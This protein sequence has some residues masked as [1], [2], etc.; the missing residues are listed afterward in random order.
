MTN[1]SLLCQLAIL[2]RNCQ[3][4]RDIRVSA[5]EL[6]R[7][8]RSGRKE[9][10]KIRESLVLFFY[11]SAVR[12]SYAKSSRLYAKDLQCPQ[13]W[14]ESLDALLPEPFRYLGSL[15]LFRALP[16]QIAP[17]VLMAYVGTQNSLCVLAYAP[18]YLQGL[19]NS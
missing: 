12:L 17:E 11:V 7:S 1:P 9:R 5:Q 4:G 19:A 2:V 3:T 10:R 15:D 13:R 16:K 8:E 6:L 18:F 14:A